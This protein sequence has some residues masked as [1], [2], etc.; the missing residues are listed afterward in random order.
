ML[1]TVRRCWNVYLGTFTLDVYLGR[2]FVICLFAAYAYTSPS[3][4][5]EHETRVATAVTTAD[6]PRVL[7][8]SSSSHV[9][10]G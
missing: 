10:A 4:R 9:L 7:P 1:A 5:L 2:A 8:F 3:T 6:L